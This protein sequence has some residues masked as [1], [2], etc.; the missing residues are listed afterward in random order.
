MIIKE[1]PDLKPVS[2][3]SNGEYIHVKGDGK[4]M[5]S[6]SIFKC[7]DGEVSCTD[8]IAV[9]TA[10]GV[11]WR[12]GDEKCQKSQSRVNKSAHLL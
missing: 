4:S 11:W 2:G 3:T 7:K 6:V 12:T 5:G 9:C 8:T 1:C 10:E